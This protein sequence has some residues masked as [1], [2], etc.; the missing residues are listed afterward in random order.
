MNTQIKNKYF[1]VIIIFS[2]IT[3]FF[4]FYSYTQNKAQEK[5]LMEK[6]PLVVND[7]RSNAYVARTS[8]QRQ[9]GLSVFSH[10]KDNESMLFL[11][12]REDFYPFW[13]K[14]M[15]FPI[16]I[17]WLNE[18]KKIVY[19]KENAKPIDFPKSYTPDKKSLYVVEFNNGFVEKNNIKIG[20]SF[21][22]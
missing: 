19:I 10:L 15:K 7:V 18:N 13:M 6:I 2:F 16:D 21:E 17:I 22:W 1:I 20:D 4:S 3:L 12:K 9:E 11:F 14:N 8:Q 5:I